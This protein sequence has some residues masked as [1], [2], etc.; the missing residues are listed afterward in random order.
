MKNYF[1][2]IIQGPQITEDTILVL[3]QPPNA[4][5]VSIETPPSL[6]ASVTDAK[7]KK[8]VVTSGWDSTPQSTNVVS[9]VV[10][11]LMPFTTT[12][13]GSVLPLSNFGISTS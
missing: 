5:H 9:Q 13:N 6:S 7:E 10:K 2:N 11:L 4:S 1:P 3:T 12:V 8:E